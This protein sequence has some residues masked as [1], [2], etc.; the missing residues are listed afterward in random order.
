MY[1]SAPAGTDWV[2]SAAISWHRE[3]RSSS[4]KRDLAASTLA[5]RSTRHASQMRVESQHCKN[6]RPT[7]PAEVI[8]HL[9]AGKIPSLCDGRVI[10]CRSRAHHGTKN[11]VSFG[12]LR[13]A[14]IIF[15]S[16]SCEAGLPV[17]TQSVSRDQLSASTSAQKTTAGQTD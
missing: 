3:E 2:R 4:A 6:E 16:R 17:R 8:G 1:T 11:R 5:S 13:P 14:R 9:C 12:V 10:F 15:V 7:T